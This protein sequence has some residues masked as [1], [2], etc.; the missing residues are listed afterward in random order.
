MKSWRA[1]LAGITLF[2]IGAASAAAQAPAAPTDLQGLA[3]RTNRIFLVWEDNSNNE[4]EFQI[5]LS[6]GFSPFSP[7]GTTPANTRFAFVGG[8]TAGTPHSFRVRAVNGGGSSAYSNVVEVTTR[9]SNAPC[10]QTDTEICLNNN[11]FRVQALY[12]TSQGT[13]GLS[14]Q[15]HA[16]KLTTDSGYLWFFD[17]TNIEVVVKV[18]NG[19]N[20]NDRFWVF[21]GGLTNVRV[22]LAVTDTELGNTQVYV[23]PLDTPFQPIQDTV[24]DLNCL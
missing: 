16:V 3:V 8:L 14:G 15:G 24:T 6:V 5:E 2:L 23:N 7:I 4:T 17:A 11:R 10:T 1:P 13:G 21:A 22:V 19:C 12:L 20:F 9:T 18:L